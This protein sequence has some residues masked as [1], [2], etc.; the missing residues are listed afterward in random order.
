[1]YLKEGAQRFDARNGS[2]FSSCQ[3][4]NSLAS[5]FFFFCKSTEGKEARRG[6]DGH[7]PAYMEIPTKENHHAA[8]N[9][10]HEIPTK[11]TEG[12]GSRGGAGV[13][14]WTLCFRLVQKKSIGTKI[15]A[16][17]GSPSFT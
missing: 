13:K 17:K 14:P 2:D 12:T 3:Q 15:L 7:R 9:G 5:F 8:A 6:D 11:D 4:L 1:M 10:I 16:P